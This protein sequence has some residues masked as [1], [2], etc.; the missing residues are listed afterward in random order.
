MSICLIC[1]KN[2][3]SDNMWIIQRFLTGHNPKTYRFCT[4][5]CLKQWVGQ[6]KVTSEN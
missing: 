5:K 6:T 3:T 1:N 4:Y 2:L